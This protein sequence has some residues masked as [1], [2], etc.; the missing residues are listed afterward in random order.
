MRKL[1]LLGLLASLSTVASAKIYEDVNQWSDEYETKFTE[2]LSSDNVYPTMFT[3]EKSKWYGIK[4]DCADAAYALRLIFSYENKLPFVI[5]NPGY[6]RRRGNAKT[7]S[8]QTSRFDKYDSAVERV[9]K[10]A[11]YL[12]SSLGSEHFTANDTYPVR[13]DSLRGGDYFTYKYQTSAGYTRHVYNIKDVNIYGNFDAIWSNQQ[14]KKEGRP[15]KMKQNMSFKHKPDRNYWGFKRFKRPE[16]ITVSQINVPENLDFSTEQYNI[17]AEQTE[18][19]FFKHVQQLH[20]QVD[21]SVDGIISKNLK[22]LCEAAIE[23]IDIVKGGV[24]FAKEINGRCMNYTEYDIYSTPS[25]D[26][27]LQSL[28]ETLA[29]DWNEVL[30][31]GEDDKV[32]LENSDLT[33]AILSADLIS[34]DQQKKLKTFCSINYKEGGEE[35]TLRELNQRFKAG[36][37]SYHPNDNIDRRWGLEKGRKTNCKVWY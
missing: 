24:D 34:E 1:V 31:N 26:N 30:S 19:G 13:L 33:K 9:I 25:R 18:K 32:Q 2:W 6:N 12:G 17:A 5:K 10:F 7:W 14:R 27:R 20:K 15:M 3:D 36:K 22:S 21:E 8:N 23:R 11:N 37:V 28:F 4:A 35:L 16:F 29:S